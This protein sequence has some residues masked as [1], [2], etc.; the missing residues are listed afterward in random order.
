MPKSAA[1]K[2]L[3]RVFVFSGMALIALVLSKGADYLVEK[4]E[5]LLVKALHNSY[6]SKNQSNR[7]CKGD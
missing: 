3:A 6:A 2:L 7:N 5:L 1:A 4:Q